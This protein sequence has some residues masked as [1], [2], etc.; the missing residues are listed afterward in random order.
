MEIKCKIPCGKGIL[1]EAGVYPDGSKAL[2][3]N[4]ND[5]FPEAWC[6][7]TVSMEIGPL[8]KGYYL[9]KTWSENKETAR[10][11][12]EQGLFEDTGERV[13]NGYVSAEIWHLKQ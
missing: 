10:M 4:C 11:L 6:T 8:P 1:Y 5:E 7:L 3:I 9:V 2:R 12:L 13:E